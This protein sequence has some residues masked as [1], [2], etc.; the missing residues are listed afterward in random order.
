[1]RKDAE[2]ILKDISFIER[3]YLVSFSYE[4]LLR[5][6]NVEYFII[7]YICMYL[8]TFHYHKDRSTE[9]GKKTIKIRKLKVFG[10]IEDNFILL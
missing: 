5:I 1:M 4:E 8:H 10:R 2:N 6:E 9:K 3:K 7:T